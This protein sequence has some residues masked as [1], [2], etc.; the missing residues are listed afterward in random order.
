MLGLGIPSPSIDTAIA[1]AAIGAT[2]WYEF[3]PS[4]ENI[5]DLPSRGDIQLTSRLLRRWF[6]KPVTPRGFVIPPVR[7]FS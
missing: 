6:S 4:A 7:A 1:S 3:V 5:A 2:V